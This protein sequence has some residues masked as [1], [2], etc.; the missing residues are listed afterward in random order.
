MMRALWEAEEH[1]RNHIW[2]QTEQSVSRRGRWGPTG[3][4]AGTWLWWEDNRCKTERPR[5]LYTT[6]CT[7]EYIK[8]NVVFLLAVT[9][10][11]VGPSRMVKTAN[12]TILPTLT[13]KS[14]L[15]INIC[16]VN[17]GE[18]AALSHRV[19]IFSPLGLNQSVEHAAYFYASCFNY[20][21]M[22]SVFINQHVHFVSR[23]VI[24]SG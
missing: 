6:S 13:H 10:P 17:L 12:I 2:K 4:Q 16:K 18:P 15:V 22:L 3:T 20:S 1:K 5:T 14:R 9:P 11:A 23:V 21:E 24:S 7:F 8:S 19:L